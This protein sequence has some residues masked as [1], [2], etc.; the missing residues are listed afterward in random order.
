MLVKISQSSALQ[1]GQ[2]LRKIDLDSITEQSR[3][4]LEMA[5]SMRSDGADQRR[6][7]KQMRYWSAA[8]F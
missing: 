4:L 6:S 8:P 2:C 5:F 7:H 3:L 1:T